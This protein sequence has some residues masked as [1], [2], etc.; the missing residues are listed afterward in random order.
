MSKGNCWKFGDNID[1]DQI[2]PSQYLV[3]PLEEMLKH[4]LETQSK[5]FAK[6][7]ESG[8]VIVAGNNFGCGSSRE[9]A[10]LVLKEV[11]IKAI[12]AQSFARIFYRNAINMGLLPIELKDTS[13]INEG[14]SISVDYKK[15]LVINETAGKK[16]SFTPLDG[17]VKNIFEE[18]G[19]IPY[20][21]KNITKE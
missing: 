7:V 3:Y 16:Y 2:L 11:G 19:L 6:E 14:D 5:E 8:D 17:M 1:T 12:I 20:I 21:N 18:G 9:Q 10:P 15:G 4:I 13:G